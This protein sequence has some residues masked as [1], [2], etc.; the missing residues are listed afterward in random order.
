[1]TLTRRSALQLLGLAAI[2]A[3]ALE[4][5]LHAWPA[6]SPAARTWEMAWLE[7]VSDASHPAR[8]AYRRLRGYVLH[9][10]LT[11]ERVQRE[12]IHTNITPGRHELD[13]TQELRASART[14]RRSHTSDRAAA[15]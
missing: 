4:V 13:D 2:D 9:G 1:M 8:R 15:G 6:L 11:S 5:Q 14:P 10:Y 3:H 12:V 7:S